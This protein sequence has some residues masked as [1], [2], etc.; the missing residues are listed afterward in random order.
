MGQKVNPISLRLGINRTWNSNWFA[1]KSY[2][3][4]LL[5]DFKIRQYL[6][7][8]FAH[9]ALSK[10]EVNRTA[11]NLSVVIYAGKPGI[12]IGRKGSE[13]DK[14]KKE[15]SQKFGKALNLGIKEVRRP[16]IDAKLIAINIAT[17]LEK[18]MAFQRVIKRSLQNV[19]RFNVTGCKI[20]ISGRLNGAEMARSEWVREG[21]IP[22]HT[23]KA[24]IDY[25]THLAHT[26]YG[27]I[28]IKVW[29]HNQSRRPAQ[30][31]KMKKETK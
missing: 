26:I 8:R 6:E 24:E 10:I 2:A 19:Q 28:G 31:K 15:L 27:T 11:S 14:L 23:L 29:V 5:E 16:D 20:Q 21:K 22:L 12:I 13:A 7:S 25:A 17:Q 4:N 30:N 1:E 18:R 3:A 9:A